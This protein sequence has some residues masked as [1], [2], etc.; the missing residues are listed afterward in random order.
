ME[1]P[2]VSLCFGAVDAIFLGRELLYSVRP[3]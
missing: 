2:A 3:G 1:E